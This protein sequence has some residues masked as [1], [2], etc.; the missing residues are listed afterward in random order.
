[1]PEYIISMPEHCAKEM[2]LNPITRCKNCKYWKTPIAYTILGKC[3]KSGETRP[4]FYFC[5]DGEQDG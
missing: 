3:E 5:W 2:S 4:D 1:M